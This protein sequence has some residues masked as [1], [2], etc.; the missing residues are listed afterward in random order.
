MPKNPISAWTDQ[1]LDVRT[2]VIDAAIASAIETF[3]G[4]DAM[5]LEPDGRGYGIT[6]Y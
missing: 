6:P 3:S 5:A 4:A 2:E 1:C